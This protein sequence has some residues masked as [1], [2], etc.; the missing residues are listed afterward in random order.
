L[1]GIILNKDLFLYVITQNYLRTGGSGAPHWAWY[2]VCN[3]NIIS[4]NWY[5]WSKYPELFLIIGWCSVF[6]LLSS[7]KSSDHILLLAIFS[8]FSFIVLTRFAW[9]PHTFVFY[10]FLALA[11]SRALVKILY[12]HLDLEALRKRLFRRV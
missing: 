9:F 11:I 5:E 7:K 8:Y 2:F 1:Y 4:E 3:W 6:S 10:P 12:S